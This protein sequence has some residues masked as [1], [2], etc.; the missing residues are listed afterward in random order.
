MTDL[1]VQPTAQH[2]PA[3]ELLRPD[4]NHY[5]VAGR[6][7]YLQES[8]GNMLTGSDVCE[9]EVNIFNSSISHKCVTV[10]NEVYG[11]G[12]FYW[13]E[14]TAASHC[15]ATN[16]EDQ[17]HIRVI[18]RQ[19][20]ETPR[21][22]LKLKTYWIEDGDIS[23]ARLSKAFRRTLV[24][25]RTCLHGPGITEMADVFIDVEYIDGVFWWQTHEIRGAV[26]QP[27]EPGAGDI[28]RYDYDGWKVNSDTEATNN[29][30]AGNL[31]IGL[32]VAKGKRA[33]AR[34]VVCC[35]RVD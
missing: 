14:A 27:Q 11:R 32:H 35:K 34:V 31:A 24:Q 2:S 20:S 33:V 26:T 8:F 18:C 17:K 15:I 16:R 3:V 25:G 7:P 6:I 5:G 30:D 23:D 22:R 9:F 13:C 12:G 28:D 1:R 19:A 21:M 4:S 10:L 29:F